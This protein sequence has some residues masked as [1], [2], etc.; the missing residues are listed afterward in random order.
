MS[1]NASF[2]LPPQLVSPRDLR[3]LLLEL[4]T[5]RAWQAQQ[6]IAKDVHRTYPI[7]EP[8]LS[9]DASTFVHEWTK[10][11]LSIE[12]I[13]DQLSRHLRTAPVMTITLAASASRDMQATIVKWCRLNLSDRILVQ[14][15]IDPTLLGGM[16]IRV[17]SRLF[18]WSY[19]T[20][21]LANKNRLKELVGHERA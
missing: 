14:F 2:T 12:A 1:S 15:R 4:E 19:R 11:G 21:L 3:E 5:L 10:M 6:D 20:K 18:D 9:R 16:T 17:N 8:E 13:I 7:N